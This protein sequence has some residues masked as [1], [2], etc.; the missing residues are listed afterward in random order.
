MKTKDFGT[1]FLFGNLV[2]NL[3][4]SPR[5]VSEVWQAKELKAAD[6]G[7]VARKGVM[8]DFFGC[9]ANKEVSG[10]RTGIEE[11]QEAGSDPE[12]GRSEQLTL[13]YSI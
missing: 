2:N 11:S 1:E 4:R 8:G 10:W 6:F 9:V 5:G 13:Y 7:S 3:W 12:R